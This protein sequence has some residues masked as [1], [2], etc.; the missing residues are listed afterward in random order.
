MMMNCYDLDDSN[1]YF[2]WASN[3]AVN[4]DWKLSLL[5]TT[6]TMLTM[7][8]MKMYYYDCDYGDDDDDYYY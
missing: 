1:L 7:R 3:N 4:A 5:L 2:E 8:L 6:T